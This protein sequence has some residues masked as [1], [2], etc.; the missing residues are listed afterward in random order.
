[1]RSWTTDSQPW[2]PHKILGDPRPR[3]TAVG[4]A[5]RPGGPRG[6]QK[7]GGER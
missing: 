6:I 3:K 5:L 4:L 1:M 7:R 2:P